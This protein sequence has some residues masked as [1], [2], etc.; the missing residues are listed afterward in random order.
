MTQITKQTKMRD[1]LSMHPDAATL[2]A[3]FGLQC[4]TC[5]GAK[6]E[7]LQQGAINHGLDVDDLL[8]ALQNLIDT[9]T[10]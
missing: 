4:S 8:A 2:L 10:S 7:S 5:S 3:S 1:I 9:K 6:H